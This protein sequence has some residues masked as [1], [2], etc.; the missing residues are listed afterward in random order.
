MAKRGRPEIQ[1]QTKLRRELLEYWTKNRSAAFTARDTGHNIKTVQNYF[2]A[3]A[4]EI[5]E[6]TNQEFITKQKAVKLNAL[7]A[8]D[9]LII[10]SQNQLDSIKEK[11]EEDPD[12]SSWESIRAAIIKDQ[13]DFINKKADLE[14]SPTLDIDLDRLVEEKLAEQ[15]SN[16]PEKAAR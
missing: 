6:E 15:P 12:N 1:D 2:R 14:V 11:C 8:M 3:F 9:E 7:A 10:E 16:D 13:M 5:Q 4:E